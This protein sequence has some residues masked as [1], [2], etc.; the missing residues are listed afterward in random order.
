MATRQLS[1]ESLAWIRERELPHPIAAITPAT[2]QPTPDLS[3]ELA[4][5][6][7]ELAGLWVRGEFV[8]VHD[9]ALAPLI[10]A[11]HDVTSLAGLFMVSEADVEEILL[12]GTR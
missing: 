8:L 7:S 4:E 6:E 10:G 2:T 5:P 12:E 11:G 1:P 9:T 3:A